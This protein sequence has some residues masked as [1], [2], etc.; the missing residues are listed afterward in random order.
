MLPTDEDDGAGEVGVVVAAALAP[1]EV[2]SS[3]SV[4][5]IGAK[6]VGGGGVTAGDDKVTVS[7]R[8]ESGV[9]LPGG[10]VGAIDVVVAEV[11]AEGVT[12]AAATTAAGLAM[13]AAV[14]AAIVLVL[15]SDLLL[16]FI[17]V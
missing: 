13:A 9:P 14:V 6:M 8:L 7:Y 16:E 1:V 2:S 11:A 4:G 17:H 15:V 5:V 10:G 12:T 3:G